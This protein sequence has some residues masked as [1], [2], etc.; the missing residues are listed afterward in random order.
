MEQDK[1]AHHLQE[2]H[3]SDSQSQHVQMLKGI[4]I[5]ALLTHVGPFRKATW[6]ITY[7]DMQN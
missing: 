5:S 1:F 2:M 3:L 4:Y 7:R 6:S